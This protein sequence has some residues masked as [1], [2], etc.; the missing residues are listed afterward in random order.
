MV[1]KIRLCGVVNVSLCVCAGPNFGRGTPFGEYGHAG[2]R[3]LQWAGMFERMCCQSLYPSQEHGK[4]NTELISKTS[5]G[6]RFL[7]KI[8]RTCP[9]VSASLPLSLSLLLPV[10]PSPSIPSSSLHSVK[11]FLHSK[12]EPAR[13]LLLPSVLANAR[14]KSSWHHLS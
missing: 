10:F 14:C 1:V 8:T 2:R 12:L 4:A 6:G 5:K 11:L 9:S 7:P 3:G 13:P